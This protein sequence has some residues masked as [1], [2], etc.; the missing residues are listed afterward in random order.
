MRRD[1]QAVLLLL[2]GGTLLKVAIT[3][4]YVRYVKPAH[5]PLL[6]IAGVVLS[7]SPAPRSGA[8]SR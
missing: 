7:P 8:K 2:V 3:G 6:V 4:T 1:T 5:L